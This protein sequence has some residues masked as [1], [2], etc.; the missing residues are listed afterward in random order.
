MREREGEG[1]REERRERWSERVRLTGR[2]KC[3]YGGFCLWSQEPTAKNGS[4]AAVL[5]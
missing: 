1:Q 4:G 2:G 3:P 5:F